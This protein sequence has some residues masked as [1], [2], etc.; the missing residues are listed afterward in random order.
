MFCF[1]CFAV[2]FL[3][4]TCCKVH[5]QNLVR[6]GDFEQYTNSGGLLLEEW[7]PG[8]YS[9]FTTPDYYNTFLWS[10]GGVHD[11]CGTLPRSGDGMIGGYQL[12]YWGAMPAY[13]REYIQGELTEP[14]KPNTLY[15]AEVYV[16]PM[17][18][19]PVINFGIKNIGIALTDKH[20]ISYDSTDAYIINETPEV[21]YSSNVINEMT[22]WTK[23]SG[24]FIAKG[25]ETKIIIGNFKTDDQTDTAQLPG[26]FGEEQFHSGMS[27][28]LFDD[29]LVK[30]MPAAFILPKDAVICRDSTLT[31]TA[32]PDNALTYEWNTGVTTQS[33]EVNKA[34][35]YSVVI[36]TAEG[37][38]QEA[39]GKVITKYCGP[40]CSELFMPNAFS[41]NDDG[42]ND[43]F[44][45]MNPEDISG[46][47]LSIY[48]RLG[49][50][51]FYT[52]KLDGK[53]DGHFRD[54][55]CDIGNYFY[56]LKYRDCKEEAY[57]KKGDLV[58]LK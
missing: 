7:V 57:V 50:R 53:W 45:P 42:N 1:R 32:Y 22:E 15:Y 4:F 43:Y 49:E 47:E 39:D 14:L 3:T 34:S 27:Y 54:R 2:L 33:I 48:N 46:M 11:Y 58:L 30:E 21:E 41:P 52:N 31:L 55:L 20:Y 44:M 10:V 23:V 28:Y 40:G 25:G 36:I 9:Y 51:V 8:W 16:K 37:C 35:N 56:Y 13:N 5:A 26:A 18:K 29:V 17:L 6:N 19:S 12:G 24:C 38:K